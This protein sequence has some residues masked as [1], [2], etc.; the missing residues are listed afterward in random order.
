MASDT[1][2]L[3]T[4]WMSAFAPTR[5][6]TPVRTAVPIPESSPLKVYVPGERLMNRKSPEPSLTAVC[7]APT[8]LSITVT[9][10][11]SVPSFAMV[12]P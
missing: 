8:P 3:S 5:T 2:G 7:G 1:D 11:S 12:L 4:S 10:G 9:P 6:P